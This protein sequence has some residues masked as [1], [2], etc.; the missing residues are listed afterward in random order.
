MMARL[1]D[2]STETI[3]DWQKTSDVITSLSFSPNGKKLLVGIYKGQCFVFSCNS[4]KYSI[5]NIDSLIFLLS[6]VK[7]DMGSSLMAEK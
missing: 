6:I 7:I 1:W 3:V 4:L 5:F 2:I